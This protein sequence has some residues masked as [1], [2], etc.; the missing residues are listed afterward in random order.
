[1]AAARIAK[2]YPDR[3]LHVSHDDFSANPVVEL[4]RIGT[5]LGLDMSEVIDRVTKGE[6]FRVEHLIGGNEF[7]HEGKMAFNPRTRGR[8]KAP[9]YYRWAAWLFAWPGAIARRNYVS[10]DRKRA[11]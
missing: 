6:A 1:M 11:A 4:E 10:P 2:E 5:F 3:V 8:R 9:R 7:K